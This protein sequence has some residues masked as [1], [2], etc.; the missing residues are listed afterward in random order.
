M[1]KNIE[2]KIK[3]RHIL[4]KK[5]RLTKTGRYPSYSWSIF[6][7]YP[8]LENLTFSF[9][10]TSSGLYTW[11]KQQ[12]RYEDT[13]EDIST[14]PCSTESETAYSVPV[15]WRLKLIC[16]FDI[17]LWLGLFGSPH[18]P[19]LNKRIVTFSFHTSFCY[20]CFGYLYDFI[21][22]LFECG[23]SRMSGCR[24]KTCWMFQDI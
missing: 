20:V 16:H 8:S 21:M 6:W 1:G 15:L 7:P 14:R 24:T 10:S 18:S 17:W 5:K 9:C 4:Q 19:Q 11:R 23:P 13:P 22:F 3:T 2:I 12:W